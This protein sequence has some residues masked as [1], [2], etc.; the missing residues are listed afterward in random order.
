MGQISGNDKAHFIKTIFFFPLLTFLLQPMV[1]EGHAQSSDAIKFI[2]ALKLFRALGSKLTMLM[3]TLLEGAS[4]IGPSPFPSGTKSLEKFT[5]NASFKS[6]YVP[7]LF[8]L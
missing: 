7:S 1:H 8:L 2:T 5:H 3:L 6:C 4:G